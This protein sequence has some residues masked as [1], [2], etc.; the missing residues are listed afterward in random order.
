MANFERVPFS[1]TNSYRSE[2]VTVG[3]ILPL[4]MGEANC[5]FAVHGCTLQFQ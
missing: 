2:G 1:I 3:S 5:M 4:S